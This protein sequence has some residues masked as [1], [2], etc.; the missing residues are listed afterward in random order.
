MKRFHGKRSQFSFESQEEYI[1]PTDM[2]DNVDDDIFID[3][4]NEIVSDSWLKKYDTNWLKNLR[5]EVNE[6]RTGYIPPR[7]KK[8][9]VRAILEWCESRDIAFGVGLNEGKYFRD[10]AT[11][12]AS[13]LLEYP[14]GDI[15]NLDAILNE[16][17]SKFRRNGDGIH[18]F[19]KATTPFI[20]ENKELLQMAY[21]QFSD[22]IEDSI[23]FK[24]Y[25]ADRVQVAEHLG[26]S[27]TAAHAQLTRIF[28]DSVIAFSNQ[29]TLSEIIQR[30]SDGKTRIAKMMR[31]DIGIERT[32]LMSESKKASS[33]KNIMLFNRCLDDVL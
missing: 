29:R 18:G 24:K 5:R 17:S 22:K 33:I 30:A 4:I 8:A 23:V 15:Q 10:V 1:S 31:R 13:T 7:K 21:E 9:F 32:T 14:F 3:V 20:S 27:N 12:V 6:Q 2:I 25:D 11:D 16:H 26:F 28:Q 19:H